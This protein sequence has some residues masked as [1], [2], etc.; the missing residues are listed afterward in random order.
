MAHLAAPMHDPGRTSI[1]LLAQAKVA[2]LACAHGVRI[3]IAQFL[4]APTGLFCSLEPL[5][6][7]AAGLTAFDRYSTRAQMPI[8]SRSREGRSR[9]PGPLLGPAQMAL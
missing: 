2:Q 8:R 5:P 6:A 9:P 7:P 3:S 1:E 4:S